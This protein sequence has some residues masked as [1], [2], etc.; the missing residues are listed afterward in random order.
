M[1][2]RRRRN[3][4]RIRRA[5]PLEFRCQTH[6]TPLTAEFPPGVGEKQYVS[7]SAALGSNPPGRKLTSIVTSTPAVPAKVAAASPWLAEYTTPTSTTS[8]RSNAPL[9]SSGYKPYVPSDYGMSG[10]PGLAITTSER[11][12]YQEQRGFPS[13][14]QPQPSLL[15]RGSPSPQPNQ[16]LWDQ[17]EAGRIVRDFGRRRESPVVGGSP[18]SMT[19]IQTS[20]PPPPSGRR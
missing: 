19:N 15:E 9:L 17:P 20:F 11:S 5:S 7:P 3:I 1:Q 4:K 2:I 14:R 10:P 12:P 8:V 18:T 16:R 6:V 13:P